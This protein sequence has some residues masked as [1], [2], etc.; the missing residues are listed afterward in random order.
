LYDSF[1]KSAKSIIK[2]NRILVNFENTIRF[3]PFFPPL[4][5]APGPRA[6]SARVRV[7]RYGARAAPGARA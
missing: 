7:G 5:R 3:F 6:A 2:I 4:S 1:F